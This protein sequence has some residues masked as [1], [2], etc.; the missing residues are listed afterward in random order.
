MR[1]QI[2][3]SVLQAGRN[4]LHSKR[5]ISRLYLDV[6]L[7]EK[8]YEV[9]IS[10]IIE[11]NKACINWNFYTVFFHVHGIRVP[12]DVRILFVE[13]NIITIMKKMATSHSCDTRTND[14][15]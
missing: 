5:H 12:A 13:F 4:M 6:Q 14:C 15:N 2:Q 3:A 11:N 9:R 8:L 1:K 7:P 10:N